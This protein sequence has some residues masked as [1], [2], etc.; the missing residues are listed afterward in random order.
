[1][2]HLLTLIILAL[3]TT[4]TY[5]ER[6]NGNQPQFHPPELETQVVFP[7]NSQGPDTVTLIRQKSYD[8]SHTLTAWII[9]T[10]NGKMHGTA[11]AFHP[12]GDTAGVY[13][14]AYGFPV[15]DVWHD[16]PCDRAIPFNP[17]TNYC[18]T[19]KH[20]SKPGML[21]YYTRSF[22]DP[23]GNMKV[24]LKSQCDGS[25]EHGETELFALSDGRKYYSFQYY[26]GLGDGWAYRIQYNGTHTDS[27]R[28]T[29]GRKFIP[30]P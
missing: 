7:P 23:Y 30:K 19:N 8:P 17:N 13:T 25:M 4:T 28:W 24:I 11:V 29:M 1:M 12:N 14:M 9:P 27:L 10:L 22:P 5:A 2:K 26:H 18:R 20:Y 16:E 6:P 3:A 15:G 21:E